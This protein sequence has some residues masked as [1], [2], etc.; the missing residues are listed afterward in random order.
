[1]RHT[2]LSDMAAELSWQEVITSW[3][4]FPL[5]N[6]HPVMRTTPD[7]LI[8]I[9]NKSCNALLRAWG[10]RIGERPP[11]AITAAILAAWQSRRKKSL[12]LECRKRIFTFGI[13]PIPD[14][15]YVNLYGIDTTARVRAESA[16]RKLNASLQREIASHTRAEKE[17]QHLNHVLKA[18]NDSSQAMLQAESEQECLDRVCRIIVEDCGHRMAWVAYADTGPEQLARPVARAG[19]DAGFLASANITWGK[20]ERGF[21]PTGT[22]IRTGKISLRRNLQRD[23]K[24]HFLAAEAR[25]R[26]Y[27]S[28]I[29]LPLKSGSRVF[30]ALTIYS[31]EISPFS[32]AEVHLLAELAAELSF[33]ITAIHLRT[34]LAHSLTQ[35]QQKEERYRLAE[36]A[37][38][39]GT[40]DWDLESG[41]ITWSAQVARLF[42]IGLDEFPGTYASFCG[43]VVPEDLAEVMAAVQV[44]RASRSVYDCTYRIRCHDGQVR[45][46]HAIGDIIEDSQSG[47]QRL[48]GVVMDV[49]EA[50]QAFEESSRLAAIVESSWDAIIGT[51]P[52]GIVTSWNPGSERMFGYTEAEMLGHSA[53]RIVPEELMGEFHQNIE[54]LKRGKRIGAFETQRRAKSGK[55]L[56]ISLSLSPV[57]DASGKTIAI[58]SIERDITHRK[59]MELAL[60]NSRDELEDRVQARTA[61]LEEINQALQNEIAER[62]QMEAQLHTLSAILAET[63]ERERRR[64]ATD[65]H[66]RI[67]QNLV[68][69]NFRLGELREATAAEIRPAAEAVYQAMQQT[70]HDLRTLTFE[71]SP[72]VLYELGFIPAVKWLIRQFEDK[73]DLV[74][75]FQESDVPG[76]IPEQTR[77][78]LFQAVRE[79]LTN[80]AKYAHAS[81][82]K[83][84]IYRRQEQFEVI[85]EDDGVG[86]D[87]GKIILVKKDNSGFGLFNIRQR[88]ESLGGELHI[89]SDSQ[90]GTRIEMI[91]P[92][93]KENP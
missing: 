71:L 27:A 51:T 29:S 21:G 90:A 19:H 43:F 65:L 72:P 53:A 64:I 38:G 54:R 49:T 86:F 15:G 55:I 74:V 18:L 37:A 20:S 93:E 30:G 91:V 25:K 81:L 9:A 79:L 39:V 87:P 47:T 82:L 58:S 24:F 17:L 2:I 13:V 26:D 42:G 52:E 50:R 60:K 36:Q 89:V 66:D 48:L 57:R 75:E 73:Y 40:W 67:I 61:Q 22:A 4:K 16:L 69:T 41:T 78:V 7:G 77:I 44:S 45:W 5:E 46:L 84:S 11:E 10:V 34:D 33:G 70:I 80:A 3:A 14:A 6:P 28:A 12:E 59:E 63:E 56:D 92:L 32:Q 23:P 62:K 35:L 8:L 68:Y 76:F 31:S 1:M 83:V 85:V 88:L